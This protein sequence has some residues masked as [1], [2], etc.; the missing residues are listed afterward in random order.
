MKGK[1][2]EEDGRTMEDGLGRIS[3]RSGGGWV[4][5][6]RE[7]GRGLSLKYATQLRWPG[8]CRHK[9]ENTPLSAESGI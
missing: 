8:T 6:G 1:E 5:G 9:F 4:E 2:E 3:Q 7:L